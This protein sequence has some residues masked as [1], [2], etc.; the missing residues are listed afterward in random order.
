MTQYLTREGLEKIKKELDYLENTKRKEVAEKLKHTAAFGDLSENAAYDEA[1]ESQSFLES[2]ILELKKII[3]DVRIIEKNNSE[4]V[5]IG[6]TVLLSAEGQK[7]E[8][9]IVGTEEA[10]IFK[11][12][13]SYLSPLGKLLLGKIKGEKAVLRTPDGGN[14]GYE[15][16]EIK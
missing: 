7:E 14:L 13:I 5:Q 8:F 12:R 2:R 16:L 15:I 10:D 6:S 4:K 11:G 9:Q 1:K 3:S